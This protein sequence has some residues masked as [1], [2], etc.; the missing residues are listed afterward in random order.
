LHLAGDLHHQCLA[1]WRPWCAL[2]NFFEKWGDEGVVELQEQL[3]ELIIL[4]ASRTLL[5]EQ[6]RL[7]L[8]SAP[9]ELYDT[10][11]TLS[12]LRSCCFVMPA[13]KFCWPC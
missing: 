12:R 10:P 8:A 6:V 4:T 5:G 13:W 9:V 3:S 11:S 1:T 7:G 2:Q